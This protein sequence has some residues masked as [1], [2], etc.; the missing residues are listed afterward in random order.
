VRRLIA[1]LA[2]V[3][4]VAAPAAARAAVAPIENLAPPNGSTVQ[5]PAAQKFEVEFTCVP[6]QG[7]P[8]FDVE[9]SGS[10]S[11]A[12]GEAPRTTLKAHSVPGAENLCAVPNPEL[13]TYGSVY[14]RATRPGCRFVE[15][16]EGAACETFGPAWSFIQQAPP[17]SPPTAPAPPTAPTTTP[18][19]P[20]P[21]PNPKSKVKP[22]SVSTWTGCGV[23]PTTP[24]SHH[25]KQGEF[26]TEFGAFIKASQ[27]VTYKLCVRFP[28][29]RK[30]CVRNEPA[31]AERTYVNRVPA[32]F[33]GRYALTW[34]VEGRAFRGVVDVAGAKVPSSPCSPPSHIGDDYPNIGE[35]KTLPDTSCTTARSAIASGHLTHSGDLVSPGWKCKTAGAA[36]Q[37][38]LVLG[39]SIECEKGKLGFSFSW[40]T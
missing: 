13:G 20:K 6:Y 11:F 12:L 31:K 5:L 39:A 21:T 34:T 28:T 25:C 7:N 9:F 26:G 22:P 40:A 1:V 4:S 37:T 8:E 17:T 15:E 36:N 33:P 29:G 23:T 38:G 27:D 16:T 18:A 3:G 2:L 10:P 35:L 14:W 24:R 30:E 19:K 32:K